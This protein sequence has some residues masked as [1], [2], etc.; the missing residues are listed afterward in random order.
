M[1][2]AIASAEV[3]DDVLG[4]DPTVQ[5]LEQVA[6]SR[7]GKE[8]ALFVPSGTMANQLAIR[9]HTRPGDEIIMEQGAHPFHYEA[10]GPA[11][12]SGVTIRPV[13]ARHGILDPD[14]VGACFRPATDYFAP[15]T[16]L[17]AED[18]SN[19]GGGSVYPLATLDALCA[20]ADAQGIATHLDGARLFNAS[21]ASGVPT[22]RRAKGFTTVSICLS[23]GLGA[24]IGSLLCG[25]KALIQTARRFRKA[26]GGGMRQVGI[27]AAGGL[28]ALENHVERLAEDHRRAGLLAEH[29][30]TLGFET[31]KPETNMVY[32]TI[33]E[34]PAQVERLLTLGVACAAVS[35]SQIRLVTHLDVDDAGIEHTVRAFAQLQQA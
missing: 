34:A 21:V 1:R 13:P 31:P 22:A 25:P 2:Q 11:L 30:R 19:R 12:I 7:L 20:L 17:C 28:H 3:G 18:T 5:R 6:A 15:I 35:P 26:L 33:S 27:I 14:K 4:D 8:A 29:L 16:L 9:I 32:L 10:G 24:P 23:K